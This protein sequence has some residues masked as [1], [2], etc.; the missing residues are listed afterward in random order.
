MIAASM[1]TPERIAAEVGA[2]PG[3]ELLVIACA[4]DRRYALPLAV[5]LRSAADNAR[6]ST[7]IEAYV[8]DDAIDP[9]DKARVELSIAGR[10]TLHWVHE[11]SA[12]LAGLPIWGR[13]SATTYR[14]LTVARWLPP[15]VSRAIWLD[16]DV[17]VLAEL[18]PLWR[19]DLA[20]RHVMAAP[21]ALVPHLSSRFGVAAHRELG[22]RPDAR[23]FNAGVL[24]SDLAAWRRDDVAGRALDYLRRYGQRVYFWD[25]EALNAVLAGSWGALD[26]R[27]N[28][29]VTIDR[30]AAPGR[31]DHS[32]AHPW[33]LHFSGN[34]KPWLYG[35]SS[36]HHQAY[37]RYLDRTAWSGSRPTPSWRATMLSAYESSRLRRIC[38]PAE[39][40]GTRIVRAVTRRYSP[41]SEE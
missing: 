32:R 11:Q 17:L 26:T 1:S 13:M 37:Y 18:E 3:G 14:K 30:L 39:Q 8:V 36:A 29:Q 20:G 31:S 12:D 15:D 24:V 28:W 7:R 38:Y 41:A 33:I 9:E 19:A 27:W 21:D 35:G 22:L 4:A 2:V 25:Q 23:Y 40:L 5:M 16:C 10:V 6:A 34:L